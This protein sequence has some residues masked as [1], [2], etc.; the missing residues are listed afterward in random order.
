MEEKRGK[1]VEGKEKAQG[2][3]DRKGQG[4]ERRRKRQE[5]E[6]KMCRCLLSGSTIVHA[7]INK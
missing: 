7:F 3:E 2:K 4:E 5:E 6:C 1:G